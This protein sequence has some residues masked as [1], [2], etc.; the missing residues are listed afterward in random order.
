M[1]TEPLWAKDAAERL[2]M[3]IKELLRL[4]YDRKIRYVMVEGIVHFPDDA[5]DEY[6]RRSAG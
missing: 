1:A 3:P 4:A 2:D 5:I 6:Q